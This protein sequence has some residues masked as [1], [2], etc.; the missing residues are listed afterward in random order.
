MINITKCQEKRQQQLTVACSWAFFLKPWVWQALLSFH[1][2]AKHAP[3]TF[4]QANLGK[5]TIRAVLYHLGL[6][7]LYYRSQCTLCLPHK[8]KDGKR[9]LFPVYWITSSLILSQAGQMRQS[10]VVAIARYF[11][12]SLFLHVDHYNYGHRLPTSLMSVWW[13]KNCVR[14][15]VKLMTGLI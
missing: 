6:C 8:W 14:G 9:E 2:S 5:M 4:P 15:N 7:V 3:R 11:L 13:F 10:G 12:K 1:H